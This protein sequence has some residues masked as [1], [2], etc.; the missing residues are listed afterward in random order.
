MIDQ[1][2]HPNRANATLSR[3]AVAAGVQASSYAHCLL[4]R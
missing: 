4:Q 1:D 2:R 3:H